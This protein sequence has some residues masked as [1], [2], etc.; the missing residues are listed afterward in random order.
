MS[1]CPLCETEDTDGYGYC[2]ECGVPTVVEGEQPRKP[3]RASL[4]SD[5]FGT[6]ITQ[7][8]LISLT[9]G[10]S[11]YLA[12][13]LGAFTEFFGFLPPGSALVIATLG[14]V[15]PCFLLG[16][17]TCPWIRPIMAFVGT[18]LP[19]LILSYFS[20]RSTPGHVKDPVNVCPFLFMIAGIGAVSI[21]CGT[22]FRESRRWHFIV[23]PIVWSASI[24]AV[25]AILS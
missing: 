21:I 5:T 25:A 6:F 20:L 15:A 24:A 1:F 22:R 10:F 4:W 13:G 3:S 12:G 14:M 16:W 9:V 8:I 11:A 18:M 19:A 23:I 2:R 7:F 17:F